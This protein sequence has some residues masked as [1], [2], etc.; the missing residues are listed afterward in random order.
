MIEIPNEKDKF[1]IEPPSPRLTSSFLGKTE[2][3]SRD[4]AV[5]G[6]ILLGITW[7]LTSFLLFWGYLIKL[8]PIQRFQFLIWLQN[9]DFYC[10]LLPL[11]IP[12]IFF[13]S[14]WNWFGMKLFRHNA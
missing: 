13:I 5:Y 2:L 9:D 6:W 11:T 14:L 12:L 7:S 8:L 10:F 3:E 4:F 1:S